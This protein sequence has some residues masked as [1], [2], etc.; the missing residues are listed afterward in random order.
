M[1]FGGNLLNPI[2]IPLLKL[3]PLFGIL[4]IS[5]VISVIIVLAYKYFTD[6]NEMKSLKGQI[7]DFQKQMKASKDNPQKVM[8][9]QKQSM[10]VNMKY[11]MKSMKPTLFTFIPIIIIFGWLNSHLAFAPI[12]PGEEFTTSI[13]LEEGAT[14]EATLEVPEGVEVVDD[15]TKQITGSAVQWKLKGDYGEHL[16]GYNVNGN[17]YTKDVLIT[18]EQAYAPI[19]QKVDN[20]IVKSISIDN[21]KLIVLNLFGWK[22]GWLGVYIIF[23]LVFSMGL[24]KLL[25]IY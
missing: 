20:G 5:L 3:P 24:R 16:L 12:I 13:V 7:K 15:T 2:F 19:V 4:L 6:Q 1:A 21:S 14:G 11:M 9:L 17:E 18:E 23:S 25:N 10:D 8:K 22:L